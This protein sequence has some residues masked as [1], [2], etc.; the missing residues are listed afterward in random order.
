MFFF[1]EKYRIIPTFW[2]EES[3]LRAI[4][5][6]RGMNDFRYRRSQTFLNNRLHVGIIIDINVRADAPGKKVG[7]PR[8]LAG[9][10]VRNAKERTDETKLSFQGK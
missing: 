5:L 9:R 7:V 8:P 3:E 4:T 6:S 10:K 1:P 2:Q